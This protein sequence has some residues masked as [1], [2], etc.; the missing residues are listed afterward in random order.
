MEKLNF[1]ISVFGA[2]MDKALHHVIFLLSACDFHSKLEAD[3]E[4]PSVQNT[5]MWAG[6]VRRCL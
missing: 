2:F 1:D 4:V 6:V 5:E 3:L